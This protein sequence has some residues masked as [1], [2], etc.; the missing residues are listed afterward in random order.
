MTAPE[1]GGERFIAVE[2]FRWMEEVAEVLRES[3]GEAAARVPKR[4]VPNLLVR[5]MTL[6]DPGIR[7]IVGQLGRRTEISS[8]NAKT[9]LGW[10]PRPTQETIID[11][12]Q[13]LIDQGV[14]KQTA[15]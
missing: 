10:S 4:T 9:L 7:S 11:C 15:Q 12:A 8:E 6:V 14:V 1:A 5:A 2:S 3:L 13:S